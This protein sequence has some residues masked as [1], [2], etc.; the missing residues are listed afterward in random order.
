MESNVRWPGLD[1]EE[2]GVEN[3]TKD[4][5]EGGRRKP[6]TLSSGPMM[7]KVRRRR[8]AGGIEEDFKTRERRCFKDS[9]TVLGMGLGMRL[10]R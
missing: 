2:S 6:G 3:Q 9:L 8:R 5:G 1:H 4:E 7:Q 10:R